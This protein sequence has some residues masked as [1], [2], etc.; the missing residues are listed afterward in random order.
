VR[1]DLDEPELPL[2]VPAAEELGG[3][4]SEPLGE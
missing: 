4:S 1:I 2:T 3:T